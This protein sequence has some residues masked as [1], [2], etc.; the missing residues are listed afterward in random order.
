[1]KYCVPQIMNMLNYKNGWMGIKMMYLGEFESMRWRICSYP[2]RGPPLLEYPPKL[3]YIPSNLGHLVLKIVVPFNIQKRNI[4]MVIYM[5][6]MILIAAIIRSRAILY[7]SC[8]GLCNGELS[9]HVQLI[10]TI[11]A[12][13]HAYIVAFPKP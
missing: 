8:I 11:C 7:Y 3:H 9:L 4:H 5:V 12:Y 6:V 13:I 2:N 1:M 10:G